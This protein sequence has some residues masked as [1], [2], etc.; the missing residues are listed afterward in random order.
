MTQMQVLWVTGYETEGRRGA[1][2]RDGGEGGRQTPEFAANESGEYGLSF[3]LHQPIFPW[4][5]SVTKW[6]SLELWK[7]WVLWLGESKGI[8]MKIKGHAYFNLSFLICRNWSRSL[9]NG[10]NQS[11]VR[12]AIVCSKR[13]GAIWQKLHP[14]RKEV[15]HPE[16]SSLAGGEMCQDKPWAGSPNTQMLDL[17][18]CW[19]GI[20]TSHTRALSLSPPHL[21]IPR[22][23]V[24]KGSLKSRG[25]S[26]GMEGFSHLCF[27]NLHWGH[28]W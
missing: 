28:V 16:S 22:G 6:F 14:L 27:Y 23:P 2:G 20:G 1:G 21:E 10:A 5:G 15:I 25:H 13:K 17:P 26:R 24:E 18:G 12:Q 19:S 8:E 3:N 7:L 11:H 4:H 9:N